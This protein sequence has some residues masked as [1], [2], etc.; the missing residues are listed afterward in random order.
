VED[1]HWIGT[2]IEAPRLSAA[3]DTALI[4]WKT[5]AGV[6]SAGIADGGE[7]LNRRTHS[8]QLSVRHVAS[9]PTG[10]MLLGN[11]ALIASMFDDR[12]APATPPS[13]ELTDVPALWPSAVFDGSSFLVT[14]TDRDV[15]KLASYTPGADQPSA[16]I[17]IGPGLDRKPAMASGGGITWIVWTEEGR[18]VGFRISG[19]ARIDPAPVVL[20]QDPRILQ[21]ATY[22][23]ASSSDRFLLAVQGTSDLLLVP[24]DGQR[25]LGTRVELGDT[26]AGKLVGDADGFAF[27]RRSSQQDFIVTRLALDGTH[28]SDHAFT[29]VEA[30]LASDGTRLLLALRVDTVRT[31]DAVSVLWLVHVPSG[32]QVEIARTQLQTRTTSSCGGSGGEGP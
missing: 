5:S 16:P 13:V 17:A 18:A 29:G 4:L 32:S 20:L 26:K 31:D 11:D 2:T 25:N 9:A 24:F 7:V 8:Q 14:W 12:G 1:S 27:L 3:G 21:D 22:S 28:R 23:L 19:G 30:S 10:H 6:H 15:M